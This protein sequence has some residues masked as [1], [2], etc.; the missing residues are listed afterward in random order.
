VN[1]EEIYT[2]RS[3]ELADTTRRLLVAI[4]TGG[5]AISFGV[6]GSLLDKGINPEW[7]YYPVILFSL[8]LIVVVFSLIAAKHKALARKR[9]HEQKKPIPLF[10]KWWQTNFVF[11]LV[12]LLIFV[13]AVFSGL[14]KLK[15]IQPQ[16]NINCSS[17]QSAT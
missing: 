16:K 14:G 3:N 9:A 2:S 5:I 10:D 15:D 8:G 12:T 13:V 7:V 6:A 4:H 11:E 17:F 1:E